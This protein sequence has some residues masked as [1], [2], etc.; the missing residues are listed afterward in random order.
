MDL[1]EEISK[2]EITRLT[3]FNNNEPLLDK[4]IYDFVRKAHEMMPTVEIGLSSNGRVVTKGVLDR[5]VKSGLTTLYI[6]IPCV[7]RENYKEV[8]GV[9]PDK[10]FDVLDL[11]DDKKILDM[12]RIAVPI[13][14]FLDEDALREKFKKYKVCVWNLEFKDSWGIKE[15]F[16]EVAREDSIAG[17]CD[18]PMDQAVISSN[19]DVIICC[20]DWQCQNVVGNVYDSSLY[21]IWHSEPMQKIQHLIAEGKYDEIECCKDCMINKEAYKR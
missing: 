15:K 1:L 17:L 9:Y 5:L 11:V 2:H 18:R 7:E 3:L 4:R 13:T 6:S 16:N 8:M 12:V 20:R 21:D 14:K 10:I 19:G